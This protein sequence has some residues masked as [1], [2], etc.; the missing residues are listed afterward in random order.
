MHCVH[1][2]CALIDIGTLGDVG[3]FTTITNTVVT[4]SG[5]SLLLK[6]KHGIVAAK[7][8][9]TIFKPIV[10]RIYCFVCSCGLWPHYKHVQHFVAQGLSKTRF[11]NSPKSSNY[12]SLAAYTCTCK[13]NKQAL[14]SFPMIFHW[15][16]PFNNF[17]L[18][19]PAQKHSYVS[20][21]VW[22]NGK[23]WYTSE[24]IHVREL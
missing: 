16:W 3:T 7:E 22:T 20:P 5:A 15:I 23:T 4:A 10:S 21:K 18:C 19:W 8:Y 24:R 11:H 17:W 13:A 1:C 6:K 2:T 14:I 12:S 9:A